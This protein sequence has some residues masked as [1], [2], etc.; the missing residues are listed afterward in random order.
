MKLFEYLE[1]YGISKEI[2]YQ[3]PEWMQ[4]ELRKEHKEYLRQE[5]ESI[6]WDSMS[7]E[8]LDQISAYETLKECGVPFDEDGYP[9]GIGD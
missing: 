5:R 9:I 7:D 4:E 8:E 3:K 6:I 1:R 2:L